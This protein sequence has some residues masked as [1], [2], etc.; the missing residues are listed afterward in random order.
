MPK[1]NFTIENIRD[2][3]ERFVRPLKHRGNRGSKATYTVT[4]N[5]NPVDGEPVQK[6]I[7]CEDWDRTLAEGLGSRVCEDNGWG[8]PGDDPAQ[9]K[10]SW[11]YNV[12]YEDL[13]R[14]H[15]FQVPKPDPDSIGRVDKLESDPEFLLKIAVTMAAK[16]GLGYDATRPLPSGS[17]RPGSSC[18]T[19][20]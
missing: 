6:A 7:L 15:G 20:P 16:S 11:L 2:I 1:F 3:L 14:H 17:P 8:K 5:W 19:Y 4:P 9:N 12:T 10:F 18:S 13:L